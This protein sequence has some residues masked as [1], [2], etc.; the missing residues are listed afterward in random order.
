MALLLRSFSILPLQS[1][2][3]LTRSFASKKSEKLEA[4]KE[5]EMAAK[6]RAK[7]QMMQKGND[8]KQTTTK[9]KKEKDSTSTTKEMNNLLQ[10]IFPKAEPAAPLSPEKQ[11]EYAQIAKTYSSKSMKLHH[12]QCQRLQQKIYL[13]HQAI[14]ALPTKELRDAA[15]KPDYTLFPPGGLLPS[16]T[17]PSSSS[18]QEFTW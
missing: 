9:A 12:A 5:K 2:K 7:I 3:V 14:N 18:E 8:G 1:C 13:M 11:A 15:S 6:K 17:P 10:F 16:C 4:K